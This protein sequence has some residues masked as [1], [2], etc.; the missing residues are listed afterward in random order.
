[1]VCH[2]KIITIYAKI[3]YRVS[4]AL[5]ILNGDNNLA[6]PKK[7]RTL[8]SQTDRRKGEKGVG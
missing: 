3:P 2:K 4:L 6:N 8:Q 5:S 7:E 1:L